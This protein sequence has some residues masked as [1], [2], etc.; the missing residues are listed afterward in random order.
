METLSLTEI[1]EGGKRWVLEAEKADFHKD[2]LEI[3]I[4]GVRVEFY[5]TSG[6]YYKV[7]GTEGVLNTK[8]RVLTLRGQVELQT[9]DLVIKT[10]VVT[11]FPGERVLV[12]P[13]D[14]TLESPKLRVQGK[15]LKVQ[16]AE[17]KLV[18]SQH[19]LT[20]VKTQEWGLKR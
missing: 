7:K 13:E 11:Y 14:V 4:T 18:L 17:K 9:G 6:E 2:R 19:R 16:L 20:E 15:G 1:Q 5:G 3:N 12:A 10:S 8:T